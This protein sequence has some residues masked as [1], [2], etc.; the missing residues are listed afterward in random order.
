MKPLLQVFGLDAIFYNIPNFRKGAQRKF[1]LKLEYLKQITA[2]DKYDKKE[3]DLKDK[4]IR[5]L[6]FDNILIQLKNKKNGNQNIRNF[7][8][9]KK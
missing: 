4:K 8:T 3:S 7:F 2:E 6:I 9:I 1:K 5:E